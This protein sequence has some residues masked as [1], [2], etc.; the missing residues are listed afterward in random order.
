MKQYTNGQPERD[1][2]PYKLAGQLFGGRKYQCTWCGK[3]IQGFRDRL[4]AQEFRITGS[5]Q[6]CQD[7]M[8]GEQQQ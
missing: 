1:P 3:E 6:Q 7:D 5:C 2:L 8:F 4:S